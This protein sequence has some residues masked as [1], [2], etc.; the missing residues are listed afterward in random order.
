MSVAAWIVIAVFAVGL[1][2][3][4]LVRMQDRLKKPVPPEVIE[5]ARRERER[6]A[7]DEE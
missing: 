6:D 1:I 5:A 2:A 4:G 7:E 3:T